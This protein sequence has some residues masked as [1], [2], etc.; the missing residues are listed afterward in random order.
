[1]VD[2]ISMSQF[3]NGILPFANDHMA[4]ASEQISE[5]DRIS[6]RNILNKQEKKFFVIK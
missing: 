3:P 2:R 6:E 5:M 1:M 4:A